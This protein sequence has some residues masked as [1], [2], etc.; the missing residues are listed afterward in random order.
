MKQTLEQAK[1][2]GSMMVGEHGDGFDIDLSQPGLPR[3]LSKAYKLAV[4]K[5]LSKQDDNWWKYL[6]RGYV[7]LC[8]NKSLCFYKI[9]LTQKMA[10]PVN[11]VRGIQQGVPFE[12]DIVKTWYV[13]FARP[14]EQLLH[15]TFQDK[16]LRGEWFQFKAEELPEIYEKIKELTERVSRITHDEINISPTAATTCG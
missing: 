13:E 3:Q 5:E 1:I 14:F 4:G 15:Y 16:H 9:G 12:L 7:Y 11:R 6:T 10:D 8:G 2:L